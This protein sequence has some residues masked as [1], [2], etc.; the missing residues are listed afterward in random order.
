MIPANLSL[1]IHP[2]SIPALSSHT[3]SQGVL[4]PIS[5]VIRISMCSNISNI[6]DTYK[7]ETLGP[8]YILLFVLGFAVNAAA[9][10]TFIGQRKAW[11]DTHIYMFNLV[12]AD[13][14][15]I[16]FLPFRIYDAFISLPKTRL[17]TFLIYTHY[18]NTYASILTTTAIS[19][20]RYLAVSQIIHILLKVD[21][22][23]EQRKSTIGIVTANMI[24]FIV[25]YTPIHIAFVANYLT[26]PPKNW[27]QV[28]MPLEIR[29]TGEGGSLVNVFQEGKSIPVLQQYLTGSAASVNLHREGSL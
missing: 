18:I 2:F 7:A 1:V 29:P 20:Q 6:T 28:Y 24:V 12:I 4:E 14:A 23:S 19:F 26:S 5:A 27:E 13:S 17:C 22:K 11:T 9:L 3:G 8:A 25:C 16:L 10:R 15:L 21:D